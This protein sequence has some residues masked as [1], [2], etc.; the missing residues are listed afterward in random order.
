MMKALTT[1]MAA[2]MKNAMTIYTKLIKRL[3][4]LKT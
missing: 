3:G 2:V 1:A 4:D